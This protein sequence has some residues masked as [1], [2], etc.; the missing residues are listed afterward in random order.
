M[1]STYLTAGTIARTFMGFALCRF[2]GVRNGDME[3]TD[4][5]FVW[6]SGLV[7]YVDEHAV[8]LPGCFA[9]HVAAK[10]DEI[11]AATIETTWWAAVGP[12]AKDR[13]G[14]DDGK[15]ECVA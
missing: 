9:A 11:E 2:C 7:E 13:S 8:R 15:G 1:I 6:P 3:Y 4:G 14:P 12:P 10:L 5:I